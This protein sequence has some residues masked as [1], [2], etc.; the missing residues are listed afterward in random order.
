MIY[1][2]S[3]YVVDGCR[4][5]SRGAG[6]SYREGLDGDLW[7]SVARHGVPDVRWIP[8]HK[9]EEYLLA[10][11]YTTQD[12]EGNAL[13]DKEASGLAM[14][15]GASRDLVEGWARRL[16]AAVVATSVIVSVQ[17]A[18]LKRVSGPVELGKT[19]SRRAAPRKHKKLGP[20]GE[21][22]DVERDVLGEAPPG[23]H[24]LKPHEGPLT[25]RDTLRLEAG[26]SGNVPWD[27]SCVK[28][29]CTK[30][31][32]GTALWVGLAREVCQVG[33][34]PEDRG[35]VWTR[36]K[37]SLVPD[38][39]GY[40][41]VR[42]S[43]AVV[44]RMKPRALASFCPAWALSRAG[45]ERPG[46]MGHAARLA[47]LG[48]EWKASRGGVVRG[49][50]WSRARVA[51]P[52]APPQRAGPQAL[53][54]Y[55]DHVQV[56]GGGFTACLACGAFKSRRKGA[57]WGQACPD[58]RQL[59]RKLSTAMKE[60][61]LDQAFLVA[62]PAVRAWAERRGWAGPPASPRPAPD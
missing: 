18:V 46:V 21:L 25:E 5:L 22:P 23:V 8:A 13:A 3:R 58:D 48:T 36:V 41:C 51:A 27:A 12:W 28:N 38:R 26:R 39:G 40:R 17:G 24:D 30:T 16:E 45:V 57:R 2:D 10:R 55:R 44:A 20:R 14:G 59:P 47:Q 4:E 19:R 7:R 32:H 52:R 49:A 53:Q 62:S 35:L 31:V 60:G 37:H 34:C 43:M 33:L 15:R 42:C 61:V 9:T 6:S 11:G 56:T 54:P 1:S 29:G 50:P